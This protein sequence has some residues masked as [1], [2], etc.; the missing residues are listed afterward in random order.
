MTIKEALDLLNLIKAY[1]PVAYTR[2]SADEA[3]TV[4]VLWQEAFKDIPVDIMVMALKRYK[5]YSTQPPTVA[6][7]REELRK[8]HDETEQFLSYEPFLKRMP[9]TEV[10]RR[11]RIL[12]A[13]GE[14]KIRAVALDGRHDT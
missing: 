5:D 13:T 6:H 11:R 1:Y 7:M 10:E 9:A 3:K 2:F 12:T 14:H 4:V 8:I